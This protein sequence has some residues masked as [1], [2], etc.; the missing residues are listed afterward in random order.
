VLESERDPTVFT[1]ELPLAE[2]PSAPG[3]FSLE[4]APAAVEP[5]AG[6]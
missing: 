2:A 4:N 3:A 5:V 6:A 1:L